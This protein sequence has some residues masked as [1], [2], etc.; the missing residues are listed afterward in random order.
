MIRLVETYARE[1]GLFY[2]P[3]ATE[4]SYSD[5]LEL[6]L[7]TVEPSLAG[8]K[9]PQDRVKLGEAQASF[10]KAL[11]AMSDASSAAKP[12]AN[13]AAVAVDVKGESRLEGEGGGGTAVGAEDPTAPSACL[14]DR[15]SMAMSRTA[16]S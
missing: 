12:K 14:I 8:P 6:D 16:R 4:A 11:K 15:S 1:Q 7:A 5:T 2:T 10:R 3:G 13:G 9:R